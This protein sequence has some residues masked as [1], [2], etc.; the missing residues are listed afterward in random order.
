MNPMKLYDYLAC[1]RPVVSTD[2]PG[3]EMFKNNAY[4]AGD[5]KNFLKSIDKALAE[6]SPEKQTAR[7]NAVLPHSWDARV[8]KMTDLIFTKLK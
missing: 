6:D 2:V 1:G 5:Q 8:K 7:R 3:V 4:V